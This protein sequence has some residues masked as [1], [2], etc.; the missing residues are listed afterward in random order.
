MNASELRD[1]DNTE[2]T[3]LEQELRNKLL[4]LGIARA[5]QRAHSPSQWRVLRRDIARIKTIKR[6]RELGLASS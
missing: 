2:L 1:K 5:T 4:K 6:E 3:E